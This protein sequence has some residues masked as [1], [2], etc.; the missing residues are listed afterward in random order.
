M[1]N[2]DDVLGYLKEERNKFI[3]ILNHDIKTP[4]LAQIQALELIL[5]SY[6]GKIL[7]FL[8]GKRVDRC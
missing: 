8:V 6:F 1:S 2:I 5:K 3:S 7:L 4:I